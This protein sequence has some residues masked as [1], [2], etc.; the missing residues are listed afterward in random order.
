MND[1]IISVENLGKRYR[2]GARSNERYT[3]LRDVIAD[4]AKSFFKKL[5]SRN[6]V[7][8]S[9]SQDVSISLR[10]VGSSRRAVGSTE[11]EAASQPFSIS[12]R[13]D[14]WALRDINFEVRRG[15]VVGIIGRNSDNESRAG[16]AGKFASIHCLFCRVS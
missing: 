4:Q 13:E 9:E 10:A 2:L 8:V 5:K 6:G 11:Q 15:E 12:P 1:V 3:A 16:G 14:F 7:S